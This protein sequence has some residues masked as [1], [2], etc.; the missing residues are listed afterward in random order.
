MS[1][2]DRTISSFKW[3]FID[4]LS[5]YFLSFVIGIILARLLTPTDYGLV[6]MSAIF[7]AVSRVFIDG[8]FSDA[9]IRKM[10]PTTDD[11]TSVFYFNIVLAVIFY[12]SLYFSSPWISDFFNEPL[13]VKIIRIAGLGLIISSTAS[14][15]VVILRKRLDFKRQAIIGFVSTMVSGI[16]SITMAFYNY[17]VWSLIYNGIIALMVSSILLWLFSSWR[18]KLN[19]KLS[20]IKEEFGFGSK[21]MAGSFINVIYNN[22]YYVLV[23]KIFSPA[24]LGFFTKA[25][26]FQKLISGNIDIIV[27]QVTYPVLA[28]IQNE[29]D[30]L[31]AIYRL[32]IKNTAFIT[33]VLLLGLAAISDYF[34]VT[35][36]GE[37]WLTSAVYLQLLCIVGIFFPLISI[38][39]NIL[40]VKGRSDLSLIV[41]LLMV[42]FSIPA[43]IIGYYLGVVFMIWGMLVSVIILYSVV[44]LF[45]QKIIQYSVKEQLKDVFPAFKI[46]ITMALPVYFV[47]Q[48]LDF[49]NLAILLIQMALGILLFFILGET[50][51]NQEYLLIKSLITKQIKKNND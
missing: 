18:P 1:L 6:G 10:E 8:G 46:G 51:E 24:A 3:S 49:P 48:F 11:Y 30:Q 29:S 33:V 44:V 16:V 40:N 2:R 15:Q 47:G 20:V 27:R 9:L 19:F 42:I 26:N 13:L 32:M 39:T 21:I 34:I 38:N 17:G 45:T 28:S 41:K 36:I 25:D 43:L 23:G 5:K 7:I 35:L 4:S 37:K 31:K 50:L 14:I 12:L 22:M